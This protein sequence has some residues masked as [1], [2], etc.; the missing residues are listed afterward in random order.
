MIR[1]PTT[2]PHQSQPRQ[3]DIF[4]RHMSDEDLN[5]MM[6]L[7]KVADGGPFPPW[8]QELVEEIRTRTEARIKK[9][10]KTAKKAAERVKAQATDD[11]PSLLASRWAQADE[12][13][14]QSLRTIAKALG[15]PEPMR[16]TRFPE[17]H[18]AAALAQGD[19]SRSS[20]KHASPENPALTAGQARL[21]DD[22]GDTVRF[23]GGKRTR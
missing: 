16:R 2:Q 23:R 18:D 8:T 21:P 10:E 3:S 9:A 13:L 12:V 6:A 15:L 20:P 11:F 14:R 7:V 17:Q 22:N 4:W 19:A 1:W 5:V